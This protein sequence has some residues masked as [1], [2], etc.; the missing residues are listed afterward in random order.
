MGAIFS[1]FAGTYFWFGKITGYQY[2][3]LLGMVHFLVKLMF[4]GVNLTFFLA[5]FLGINVYM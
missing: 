2:N 1:I 5:T 3:E 4:I